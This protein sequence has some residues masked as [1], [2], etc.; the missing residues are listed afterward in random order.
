MKY[1]WQGVSFYYCIPNPWYAPIHKRKTAF[2]KYSYSIPEKEIIMKNRN[3]TIFKISI[4]ITMKRLGYHIYTVIIFTGNPVNPYKFMRFCHRTSGA[5]FC[6]LRPF[7]N[8][9]SWW[10]ESL[11][12]FWAYIHSWPIHSY[13]KIFS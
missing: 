1:E 7:E 3:L 4:M 12:C 5:Y 2:V 9:T 13:F 8:L 11:F 10:Q 6:V